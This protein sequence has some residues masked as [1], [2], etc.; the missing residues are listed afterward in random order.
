[1]KESIEA[2]TLKDP[3]F[4]YIPNIFIL[5]CKYNKRSKQERKPIRR[6]RKRGFLLL[7]RVKTQISKD[8]YTVNEN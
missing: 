8:W 6:L 1:M 4:H 2:P 3:N 7:D 5:T